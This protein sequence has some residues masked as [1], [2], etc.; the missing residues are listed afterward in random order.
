MS[1]PKYM[2]EWAKNLDMESIRNNINPDRFSNGYPKGQGV[3]PTVDEWN[4]LGKHLTDW[5]EYL[6][7]K[8]GD[9]GSDIS[10]LQTD[11]EL[12]KIEYENISNDYLSCKSGFVSIHSDNS[13]DISFTG[14]RTMQVYV[15][16]TGKTNN[17]FDTSTL[18]YLTTYNVTGA[19]I[20]NTTGNNSIKS[21]KF[22][23]PQELY[24]TVVSLDNDYRLGSVMEVGV[25]MVPCSIEPLI[26]SVNGVDTITGF[27]LERIDIG[28]FVTNDFVI[29]G[30]NFICLTK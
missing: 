7:S 22:S 17:P 25:G 24:R 27:V 29:G 5:V 30:F 23:F 9:S 10:D 1:K 16:R 6:D 8:V 18:C 2:P 20:K 21:I 15:S 11:V 28:F 13:N 4:Y 19:T 14:N 26:E 3:Y 12:L